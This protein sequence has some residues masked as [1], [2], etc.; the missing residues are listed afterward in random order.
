MLDKL[1]KSYPNV[2]INVIE[3]K[4]RNNRENGLGV[5]VNTNLSEKMNMDILIIFRRLNSKFWFEMKLVSAWDTGIGCPL[6]HKGVTK[7]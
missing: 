5:I 2:K 3:I 6:V 7:L 4:E 1:F